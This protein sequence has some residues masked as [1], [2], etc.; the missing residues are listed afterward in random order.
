VAAY[1][2]EIDTHIIKRPV[3]S[4]AGFSLAVSQVVS[5][6]SCLVLNCKLFEM[7]SQLSLLLRDHPALQIIKDGSRVL[8][9]YYII[10][11]WQKD[12]LMF[13]ILNKYIIA[14][15]THVVAI[16]CN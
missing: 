1:F 10:C 15:D 2:G 7:N 13:Q 5:R 12:M 11:L 8:S 6:R 3:S 16:R 14:C 9:Y 4:Y